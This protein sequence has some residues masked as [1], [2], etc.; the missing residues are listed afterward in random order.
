[1]PDPACET[2]HRIAEAL[3]PLR[4]G[5]LQENVH[6]TFAAALPNEYVTRCE[7]CLENT[8]NEMN[9]M[10]DSLKEAVNQIDNI[11]AKQKWNN[12]LFFSPLLTL[13]YLKS[14]D[15]TMKGKD[16]IVRGI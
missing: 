7:Q 11:A 1:V 4:F 3:S 14:V 5:P 2:H 10:I 6:W 15:R 9:H 8:I 13:Q 16:P 12:T